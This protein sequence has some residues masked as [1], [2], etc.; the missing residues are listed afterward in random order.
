MTK[1]ADHGE[2]RGKRQPGQTAAEY[3][4]SAS[5]GGSG[6]NMWKVLGWMEDDDFCL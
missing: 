1:W 6:R 4:K 3:V 5:R 2:I